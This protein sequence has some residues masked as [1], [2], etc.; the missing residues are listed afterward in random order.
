MQSIRLA[1]APTAQQIPAVRVR[2]RQRIAAFSVA[3]PEPPFEVGTP[4]LI[5]RFGV[6]EWL[7]VGRRF[8][9]F[10]PLGNQTSTMQEFMNRTGR[11]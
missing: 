3:T 10:M 1:H 6:S 4:D 2:N 11:R 9:P 8:A 5:R 7:A